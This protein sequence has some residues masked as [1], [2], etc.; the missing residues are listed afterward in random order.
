MSG[1]FLP[2]PHSKNSTPPCDSG[3][4]PADPQ[5]GFCC[6]CDK[7]TRTNP[8]GNVTNNIPPSLSL[9]I[10]YITFI[11][12]TEKHRMTDTIDPRILAILSREDITYEEKRR[13]IDLLL[14]R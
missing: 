8:E 7:T 2:V 14:G 9:L 5:G 6:R 4:P 1:G 10:G 3:N 13:L 12:L 11:P